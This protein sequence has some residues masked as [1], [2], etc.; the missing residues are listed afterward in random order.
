MFLCFQ[1]SARPAE[2]GGVAGM[3]KLEMVIVEN[4]K[5]EF[6]RERWKS[7]TAVLSANFRFTSRNKVRVFSSGLNEQALSVSHYRYSLLHSGLAA[8]VS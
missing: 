1:S 6:A 8:W 4:S 5:A 2:Q 7:C 3:Q